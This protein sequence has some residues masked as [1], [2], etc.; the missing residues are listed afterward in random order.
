MKQNALVQMTTKCSATSHHG[1]Y[2]VHDSKSNMKNRNRIEIISQIL[3]IASGGG[4]TK[5]KIMYKA[6]LSYAQLKEYLEILIQNDLLANDTPAIYKTTS[7]GLRF[8]SATLKM[9]V[10]FN[11]HRN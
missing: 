3:D 1:A 4:A 9:D 6:F 7:K 5:T 10:M 2:V 8:L 11:I